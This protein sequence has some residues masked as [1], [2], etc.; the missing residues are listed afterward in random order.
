MRITF[1]LL[2]FTLAA[3]PAA[4]QPRI[5]VTDGDTIRVDGRAARLVGFD[6]PETWRP[7]CDAERALGE[8]ATLRLEAL[9]ATGEPAF[10]EVACSCPARTLG[11]QACNFG[12]ICGVLAVDG[13]DVADKLIAEGLARS[14]VCGATRCPP[15]PDWCAILTPPAPGR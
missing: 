6:T 14:Y 4:A 11:T 15:T 9:L 2:A 8:R 13:R 5:T 7:D 1:G 3:L 12:R 10:R